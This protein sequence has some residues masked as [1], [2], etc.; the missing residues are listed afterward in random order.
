MNQDVLSDSRS[1]DEFFFEDNPISETAKSDPSSKGD[2]IGR[3][4]WSVHDKQLK[5]LI[6]AQPERWR[7]G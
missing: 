2:A 3:R 1:V 6:L 7:R 4:N 5:S